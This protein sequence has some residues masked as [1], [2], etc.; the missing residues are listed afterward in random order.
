[1]E[2]NFNNIL[3]DYQAL[4]AGFALIGLAFFFASKVDRFL[5]RDK[6]HK[7]FQMPRDKKE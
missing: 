3:R 1:M 7:K 4:A 2:S 5:N 6:K